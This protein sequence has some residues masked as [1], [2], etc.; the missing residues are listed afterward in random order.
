MSLNAGIAAPP[1]TASQQLTGDIAVRSRRLVHRYGG[2]TLFPPE[3]FRIESKRLV[4]FNLATGLFWLLAYLALAM[5]NVYLTEADPLVPIHKCVDQSPT[6]GVLHDQHFAPCDNNKGTI[7]APHYMAARAEREAN[8]ADSSQQHNHS[9]RSYH[10]RASPDGKIDPGYDR[11]HYTAVTLQCWAT[12][13]CPHQPVLGDRQCSS[14]RFECNLVTQ[15]ESSI[16]SYLIWS[17]LLG[18]VAG[19]FEVR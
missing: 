16:A 3:R 18:Y 5:V 2:F 8:F 12:C 13:R 6:C 11:A 9:H 7:T 10:Y 4:R 15:L 14:L 17:A 1:P 19:R